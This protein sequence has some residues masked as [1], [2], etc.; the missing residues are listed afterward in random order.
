MNFEKYMVITNAGIVSG[1][2][3]TLIYIVSQG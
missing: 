3:V 1:V 2:W